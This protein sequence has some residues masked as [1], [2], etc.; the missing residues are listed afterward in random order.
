MSADMDLS[1][2]IARAREA[3]LSELT[4][5]AAEQGHADAQCCLGQCYMTGDGIEEDL[6][7]AL[8]WL[9]KAVEQGHADAQYGMGVSYVRGDGVTQ[10]SVQALTWLRKAAEQGHASAQFKLGVCCRDGFGILQNYEDAY[11][12]FLKASVG[13][14]GEAKAR[15]DKAKSDLERDHLTQSLVCLIYK[16]AAADE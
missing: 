9:R 10:D 14:T 7:Q 15:C 1:T 12:W 2:L 4:I 6:G 16:S 8:T 11:R 5:D 3:G 13:L